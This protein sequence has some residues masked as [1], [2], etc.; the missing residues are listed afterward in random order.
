[1]NNK[2]V[3][4]LGGYGGVGK[5]LCRLLM[6]ETH[7]D[8]V[9]AGRRKVK[10]EEF[11][12]VLNTEYDSN[13]ASARYAEASDLES[14]RDALQG[15][16]MV[17]VTTTTPQYIKQIAQTALAAGCDYLD[18][19][20]SQYTPRVLGSLAVDAERAGRMLITQEGF[21]PGLPAPFIRHAAQYFDDYRKAIVNMAMAMAGRIGT[22]ESFYGI[23]DSF[24]DYNPEVFKEGKWMKASYWSTKD[25]VTTDFGPGFGVQRYC[26]PMEMAEIKPLPETLGLKETGVYMAWGPFPLIVILIFPFMWL[27]QK[28]RREMGRHFWGRTVCWAVSRS[29]PSKVGVAMVLEAEGTKNGKP[30]RVRIEAEHADGYFFTAAPVAACLDLP[31]QNRSR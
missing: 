1:M 21:H 17:V 4:I 28:I 12:G 31:S 18:V 27:S 7:V 15:V 9:V 23:I 30:M 29:S 26:F 8:L 25:L 2:T 3:L 24:E 14:L 6:K 16:D 22:P 13:R 11:A 19:M 20:Y 5:S 10:A